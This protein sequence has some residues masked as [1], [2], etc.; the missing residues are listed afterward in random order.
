MPA[1]HPH[2]AVSRDVVAYYHHPIKAP[3]LREAV[4]PLAEE[5]TSRG[6]AAHVERHWLHGPHLRL[7]L[8]GEPKQVGAAAEDAAREL[9]GWV[10]AHPSH[11][12]LSEAELLERAAETGRAELVPPPYGPIVAD[13]TVRTEPVDLSAPRG[14]LGDDGLALRDD[15]MRRGLAPLRA[16]AEFLGAHGDGATART[17]LV[18]AALAAHAAAHP[19][20]LAGGHYSYVS[21]LEDFLV[22]DDPDGRLR[23]AFEQRWESAGQAVTTLVGR[24]ADGGARDGER[25]WAAWSAAAWRLARSRHDAG[26]D[27]HGFPLEYRVRAAATGDRAAMERWNQDIRT[28][29]SEFHRLLRRSDPQGTMWSRPE[30]LIYRACTNALYRLLAICDVRPLERY[31]AA[32]LVVR[33]V[34]ELTGCDWRTEVESVIDAVEGRS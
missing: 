5:W 34:P 1:A 7:R 8:T 25:A 28:R 31:L 13:N 22:H 14:L 30:Y 21:H 33:T 3:L 26:A 4:L 9:R 6:L 23:E 20:G 18:V 2:R 10:E 15:L 16:G 19:E 32:F 24:I 12:D 11:S 17:Q 27:L 29:Y